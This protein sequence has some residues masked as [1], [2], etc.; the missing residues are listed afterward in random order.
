[1]LRWVTPILVIWT[2]V[3]IILHCCGVGEF[4]QWPICAWITHWSCMCL[5][6]WDLLIGVGALF[7]LLII[8]LA[9]RF[10]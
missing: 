7:V 3:A 4:A 10:R 6:L 9:E 1:M 8:Q 2:L 5:L